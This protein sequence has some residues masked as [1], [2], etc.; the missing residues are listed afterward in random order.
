MGWHW[1]F[2]MAFNR[3]KFLICLISLTDL[4]LFNCMVEDKSIFQSVS[5]WCNMLSQDQPG[6]NIGPPVP[7]FTG[8]RFCRNP[9]FGAAACLMLVLFLTNWYLI[10]FVIAVCFRLIA[11]SD[12]NIAL[13]INTS[14]S[15]LTPLVLDQTQLLEK[16][17]EETKP[18]FPRYFEL[19]ICRCLA[20]Q[21]F[22]SV[23]GI[24]CKSR[25]WPPLFGVSLCS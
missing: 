10:V 21:L 7:G 22:P 13:K 25:K 12:T 1:Q 3:N 24:S 20:G 9:N 19:E 15:S 17:K 16:K 11:S 18:F 6:Q 2:S 23:E 5:G 4:K 14:F 8:L